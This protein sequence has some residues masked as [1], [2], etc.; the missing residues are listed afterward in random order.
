MAKQVN[1]E[2]KK[3]KI[4]LAA[5]KVFAEKGFYKTTIADISKEAGI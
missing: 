4:I 2:K 3:E 5:L 1:K